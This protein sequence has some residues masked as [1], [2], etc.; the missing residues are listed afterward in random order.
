MRHLWGIVLVVGCGT[1]E[2]A[3]PDAQQSIDSPRAID[4][5]VDAP[6]PIDAAIDAPVGHTV[7]ATPAMWLRMDDTP[8]DG[9]LDSAAAPHTATCTSCPTVDTGQFASSYKFANNRIDV[10]NTADI[11]PNGAFTIATW[12]RLDVA[13]TGVTVIACKGQGSIDC[14]YGLLVE[15]NGFPG[16]YSMGGAH[17]QG[18][19][20]MPVN[21]WHHLAMTWDGT[22]KTGYLDGT[23]AGTAALAPPANDTGVLSIGDR[24][25]SSIPLVGTLD[26]FV[27]YDRALSGA[28][29]AALA[30][31]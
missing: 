18:A 3:K 5:A 2:R 4:A 26:D 10:A 7:P 22:T 21:T 28:E 23:V 8:T 30:T 31:P 9:A 27:F 13:N 6:R 25:S 24:A 17:L 29:I 12:V 15:P 11:G 14:T 16:F 19:T 1:V 20:A